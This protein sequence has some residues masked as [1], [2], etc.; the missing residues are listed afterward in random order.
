MLHQV[1]KGKIY[2]PVDEDVGSVLK[3][4]VTAIDRNAFPIESG[5]PL[6]SQSPR[7]RQTPEPP[8]RHMVP[9]PQGGHGK[10]DFTFTVL[11][12]NVLADIYATVSSL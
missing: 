8:L 2:T 1:G 10:G 12:Y 5:V 11:T 9:L 7:V 6:S 3:V 4:E